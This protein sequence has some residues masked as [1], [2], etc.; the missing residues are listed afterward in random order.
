MSHVVIKENINRL[1][2]ERSWRV[3]QLENKIGQGRP[4]KNILSGASSNPTIE[5]LLQIAR[6]FNVEI[7]DL[8]IDH[9]DISTVNLDLLSDT[10]KKVIK[11]LYPISKSVTLTHS[12][13]I[14]IVKECY[15]YSLKL[16]L[17]SADINF[18]N[19]VIQQH[20]K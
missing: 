12:N 10:Y 19:W 14:M 9:N 3:S 16:K 18:I 4:I 17:N 11:Q 6:A 15:E 20:Y 8:L 2:K 13:I 5:V 7:Q 1:L